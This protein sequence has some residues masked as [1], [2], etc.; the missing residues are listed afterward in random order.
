LFLALFLKEK[1]RVVDVSAVALGFLGVAVTI[2]SASKDVLG[3]ASLLGN[4]LELGAAATWALFL[5]GASKVFSRERTSEEK[6]A[7]LLKIF[8]V[9][10][11]LLSPSLLFLPALSPA[12]Y[13]WLFAL[14]L[15]STF[16]AYWAWFEAASRLPALTGALV[17]NLTIVFVFLNSALFLGEEFPFAT[18]LGAALIIAGITL[19]KTR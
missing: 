18:L 1:T 14:A 3:G 17:F 12:D 6:L 10:A 8:S 16:F 2:S 15:F 11:L 19:S 7:N 13:A 5:L 9:G 4:A